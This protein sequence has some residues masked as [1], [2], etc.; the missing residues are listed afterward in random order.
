MNKGRKDYK[1]WEISALYGISEPLSKPIN[2]TP[3]GFAGPV[4]R[5]SSK[6]AGPAPI[7]SFY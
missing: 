7:P 6:T 4:S 5:E 3:P 1:E 2:N